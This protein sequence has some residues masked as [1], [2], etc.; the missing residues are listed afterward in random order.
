[1]QAQEESPFSG[2]YQI[3]APDFRVQGRVWG[4]RIL[5]F[6]VLGF[7]FIVVSVFEV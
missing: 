6:M 3:K 1:M 5:S 2:P 7:M 4:F